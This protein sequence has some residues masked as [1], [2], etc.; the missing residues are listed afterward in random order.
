MV[1]DSIDSSVLAFVRSAALIPPGN[2]PELNVTAEGAAELNP[3]LTVGIVP[4]KL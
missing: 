1:P 4:S 2:C 3:R